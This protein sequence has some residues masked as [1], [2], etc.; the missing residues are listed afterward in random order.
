ME[1]YFQALD[2][3]GRA[4]QT[5]RSGTYAH[6]GELLACA[7]CHEPTHQA[8]PA[9]AAPPLAIQRPPSVLKP[10]PEGSYPL[11]FARLV[12]PVLDRHCV[13]CHSGARSN[14]PDLTG[15]LFDEASGPGK[16]VS[17]PEW[18]AGVRHARHGWSRAYVNLAPLGWGMSGGNGI[19]F[20]EEQ[21]S[22]PGR[23]G[24][25]AS[26]LALMLSTGHHDVKLSSED[27][28]RLIIWLDCN[29]LFYGAYHEP[30]RQALG[31]LIPPR[32]GFLPEFAR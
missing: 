18:L 19:I 11:S 2:S 32:L 17:A 26:H 6:P 20:K 12:Q 7:G 23:V 5:M 21:F 4:V 14:I 15:R 31:E 28:E 16:Q 29:S 8:P 3:R 25:D 1:V 13:R 9:S 27:W 10:G 24:A 22:T 30:V